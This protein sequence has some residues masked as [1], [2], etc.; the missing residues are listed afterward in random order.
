MN[1]ESFLRIDY[2]GNKIWENKNGELHRLDGPA[3]EDLNGTKEW[4]QNGKLHRLDGPAIEGTNGD[5]RWYQNGRLHRSDGPAI[6]RSKGIGKE[7][8]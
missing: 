2:N 3:Y 1:S 6:E 8:M 4:H 5:K 7:W